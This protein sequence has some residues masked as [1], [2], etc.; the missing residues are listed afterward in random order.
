MAD[1]RTLDLNLLKAFAALLDEGSVTRAAD[2]LALTQPAVSGMLQRLRENFGDPLFVRT[3]R[4]IAPTSRALALADGVRHVLA[5][6]DTMLQPP[7]FDPA[8]ADQTLTLAATDYALRA[9][10]APFMAALHRQAPRMR[11]AVLPID[12]ARVQGQ[13]ER[14]ELDL[15]LMTPESCPAGLLTRHLFD[16]T[17][18]CALRRGHPAAQGP[19]TLE[20]FCALD[21]AIVSYGGGSFSGATDAALA[22]LAAL[23]L[24]RRVVLSVPGFLALPD[25][26]RGSDLVAAVPRRLV[27]EREEL[28]LLAPPL[29]IAGFTK[30]IVWHERTDNDPARRWARELLFETIAGRN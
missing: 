16:E 7:L 29:A 28:L 30:L 13:L 14:G 18:I 21:H 22:A 2:R 12:D 26:L 15:A 6:I 5:T 20:R 3:R 11:L 9:V 19:L 27:S 24:T 23:G 1:L 10:V 25:V 4:G 8:S 17:Y